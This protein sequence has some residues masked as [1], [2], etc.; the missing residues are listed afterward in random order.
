MWAAGIKKALS[1]KKGR[2]YVKK[3][4]L[5]LDRDINFAVPVPNR[6]EDLKKAAFISGLRF[7]RYDFMGQI[8]AAGIF[9]ILASGS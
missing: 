5:S 6:R 7:L 3:R 9:L 8:K 1:Y 2:A 4:R